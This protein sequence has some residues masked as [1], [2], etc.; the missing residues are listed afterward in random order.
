MFESSE[1]FERLV[2]RNAGK[3]ERFHAPAL[4][5]EHAAKQQHPEK[6]AT[7]ERPDRAGRRTGV[8]VIQPVMD[9]AAFF[10]SDN[11]EFSGD[12]ELEEWAGSSSRLLDGD[13]S[14]NAGEDD[15]KTVEWGEQNIVRSATPQRQERA[16]AERPQA[17]ASILKTPMGRRREELH[18]SFSAETEL[19]H[20]A[21]TQSFPFRYRKKLRTPNN[22]NN[23]NTSTAAEEGVQKEE[24]RKIE[25]SQ[26]GSATASTSYIQ[27]HQRQHPQSATSSA[28]PSRYATAFGDGQIYVDQHH[29]ANH[30]REDEENSSLVQQLP[31][32]DE[33]KKT[34]SAKRPSAYQEQPWGLSAIEEQD[35]PEDETFCP[36]ER[37]KGDIS[38]EGAAEETMDVPTPL[39]ETR[40]KPLRFMG[41]VVHRVSPR[42][43]QVAALPPPCFGQ[44]RS[45]RMKMV[46]LQFWKGERVGY[47]SVGAAFEVVDVFIAN[48]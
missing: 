22:N 26:Y 23:N 6:E 14:S 9:V 37:T 41:G 43:M 42:E 18:V 31:N 17:P 5:Q 40:K 13:N 36:Q 12:D 16:A 8:R 32:E 1:L 2:E 39:L 19:Q 35:D 27:R 4:G 33:K 45:S 7:A 28:V 24:Q 10:A 3:R 38:Y 29:D 21:A 11:E 46:P 47:R 48:E 20:N 30:L 15:Q 25:S 34:G 44:R